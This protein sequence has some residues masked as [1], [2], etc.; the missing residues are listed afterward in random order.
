MEEKIQSD[1]IEKIYIGKIILL[2]EI[3]LFYCVQHLLGYQTNFDHTRIINLKIQIL[4]K[5]HYA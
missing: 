4:L 1:K 5:F 3:R 2:T